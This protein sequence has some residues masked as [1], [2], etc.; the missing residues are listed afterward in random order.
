MES[1][2]L[3][4]GTSH[5]PQS[6]DA[7]AAAQ[8]LVSQLGQLNLN[9]VGGFLGFGSHTDGAPA[10]FSGKTVIGAGVIS[11]ATPCATRAC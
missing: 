1:I 5:T 6:I 3:T 9:R 2:P 11:T 10:I 8:A 7:S 4:I